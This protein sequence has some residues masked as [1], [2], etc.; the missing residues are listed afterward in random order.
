MIMYGLYPAQLYDCFS[1]FGAGYKLSDSVVS[2]NPSWMWKLF[3]TLTRLYARNHHV[4]AFSLDDRDIRSMSFRTQT[5]RYTSAP[6]R[7]C[8]CLPAPLAATT[9]WNIWPC[10]DIDFEPTTL[11]TYPVHLTLVHNI[12]YFVKIHKPFGRTPR[13]THRHGRTIWIGLHSDSD[14]P[15]GDGCRKTGRQYCGRKPITVLSVKATQT[16]LLSYKQTAWC[17]SL[18][19]ARHSEGSAIFSHF[20]QWQLT[21]RDTV[22]V[23]VRVRV[24]RLVVAISRTIPCNHHEWRLSE[25]RT[26]RNGGPSEWRTGT[27]S[28]CMTLWRSTSV[29]VCGVMYRQPDVVHTKL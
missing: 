6:K 21:V 10:F 23:G 11:K 17:H 20:Q 22:T 15:I 12:C 18:V 19:L 9:H 28:F 24:S 13:R 7:R 29:C 8:G 4:T 16:V 14:T 2:D 27:H 26:F 5:G 3:W 25:W 1:D